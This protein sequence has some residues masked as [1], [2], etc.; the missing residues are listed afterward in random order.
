MMGY[1]PPPQ[2]NLFILGIIVLGNKPLRRD[3]PLD[4]TTDIPKGE[5]N[6]EYKLY[7]KEVFENVY[8]TKVFIF[9]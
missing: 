8:S 3:P 4:P 5:R 1:Q 9:G 6:R 2:E 7:L